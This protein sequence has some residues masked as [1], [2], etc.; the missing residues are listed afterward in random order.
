MTADDHNGPAPVR[1]SRHL[2]SD[3]P[4]VVAAEMVDAN[5]VTYAGELA[6]KLLLA[7]DRVTR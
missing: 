1:R 7:I 2:L 6:A 3:A 4:E 5:G